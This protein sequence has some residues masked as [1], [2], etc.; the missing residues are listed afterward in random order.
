MGLGPGQGS[1]SGKLKEMDKPVIDFFTDLI[2]E[3]NVQDI[4]FQV[5]KD[6]ADAA[7]L[8]PNEYFSFI[9]IDAGHDYPHGGV[10]RAV[11]EFFTDVREEKPHSWSVVK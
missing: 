8:F 10:K 1:E 9:F 4:I 2:Y 5:R 7:A 11:H 3:A 6:S